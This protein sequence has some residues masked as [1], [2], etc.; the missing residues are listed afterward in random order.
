MPAHFLFATAVTFV[1]IG[2][3]YCLLHFTSIGVQMR[4][5]AQ[6]VET[7]RLMGIRTTLV[8]AFTWALT[9]AFAGVGGL[10]LAPIWLVDVDIGDSVAL[11][12]FAAAIIGGFGSIPGAVVGGLLV[13]FSE[14]FAAGYISTNY[15]DV[16]VFGVMI[17]FLL[18]KPQGLFGERIKER[19]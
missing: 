7:A 5:I 12:A 4:A 8:L 9:W 15:K 10:L 14:I 19:G 11:K 6:D 13:G 16:V 17:G 2:G 18:L 3:L 1:L